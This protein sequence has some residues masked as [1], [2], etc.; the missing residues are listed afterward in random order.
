MNMTNQ[1]NFKSLVDAANKELNDPARN[2]IVGAPP[3]KHLDLNSTMPG[4]P[5]AP[6]KFVRC[7][8]K[9]T[10]LAGLTKWLS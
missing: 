8:R 3:V 9:K 10:L 6:R 2:R 5:S 4:F 1:Q 7:W